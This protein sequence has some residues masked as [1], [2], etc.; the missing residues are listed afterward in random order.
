[1]DEILLLRGIRSTWISRCIDALSTTLGTAAHA[2]IANQV[3]LFVELIEHAIESG[4]MSWL[5]SIIAD[6]A[7]AMT[8]TDLESRQPSLCLFIQELSKITRQVCHQSLPLEHYQALSDALAPCFDY[9]YV[10]AAEFEIQ[11]RINYA[12]EQLSLMKQSM[13]R[14]D[15]TKSDFISVASHELRTPLTLIEGYAAILRENLERETT[16]RPNDSSTNSNILLLDGIHNGARRLRGIVD[17][18]VDVSMIDNNLLNL[19]FQPVWINRLFTALR[20]ELRESLQER[21]QLLEILD[22][23]GSNEMTFG[24]PERLLQ[25]FRNLLTNA[26]K[27]S[28]DNKTIQV[29]GRRLPGFLE[30]LVHDNGIGIASEDISRIFEKFFRVGDPALHSTSKTKFK[31]GGPGLGLHIAKGIVDAHGGAIWAES[32]GFDETACPGSTFHVILPLRNQAPDIKMTKAFSPAT[33]YFPERI[34]HK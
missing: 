2:E 27:Y 4:E 24:D 21:K 11:S 22:F 32:P 3:E 14:L 16:F 1:M 20:N 19:N 8:T 6:W 28:P 31:G 26:I 34:I 7:A 25:V 10:K 5:D 33:P 23:S 30:V 18:M 29:N 9:A 15:R 13:E 17:D 12:S